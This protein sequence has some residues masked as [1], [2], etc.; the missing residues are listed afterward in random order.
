MK[1]EIAE[2]LLIIT[3]ALV[4]CICAALL[5]ANASAENAVDLANT[6]DH[7]GW[8]DVCTLP[9]GGLVLA[10]YTEIPTE[11]GPDK[12]RIL[13]LNPDCTVRWTYTDPDA[14][15]YGTVR[16]RDDG[17]IAAY[18]FDGVKFFT[19]DGKPA[20]KNIFLPYT[21]G[22]VY[23]ITS[24]GILSARR[25]GDEDQAGSLE[26]VDW[27]GNTLFRIGEPESMWVGS[28]P[29]EEKDSLVLFGQE[30]GDPAEA[31][32][33]VMK[34][35][36]Q[37][38]IAWTSLMPFLSDKRDCTGVRGCCKTGDGGYL[39][40]L[41][42]NTADP[43]TGAGGGKNAL[44]RLDPAGNL[45]WIHPSDFSFWETVEYDGKIV[46][47]MLVPEQ[48]TNRSYI[49]YLWL[50]TDGNELGT[51][52][53]HLR[54]EDLPRYVD[55]GNMNLSVEKLIPAGGSLCQVLCFWDTDEPEEEDPAW[56]QQDNLL[57]PVPEL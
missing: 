27:N 53:L 36:L 30:A 25:D 6:P 47:C 50:D 57:L 55:P 14:F 29:I 44:I 28:A 4:L 46:G 43:E 56:I 41:W 20:G 18:C 9:D 52:E 39:A 15:S 7:D 51:T 26:M 16:V 8:L 10:G 54:D 24:C 37:G 2:S 11:D 48:D 40:V 23:D 32:A 34:V 12:G 17:T 1:K 19:P 49:R 13:C 21:G 42:D 5:C 31:P 3:Y 22:N 38:N 35:D 33:A 45:L